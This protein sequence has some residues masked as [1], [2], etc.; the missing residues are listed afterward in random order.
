MEFEIDTNYQVHISE[1][2][3]TD[4]DIADDGTLEPD[5]YDISTH[6]ITIDQYGEITIE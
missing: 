3:M 5:I 2:G 1:T 6:L 4:G